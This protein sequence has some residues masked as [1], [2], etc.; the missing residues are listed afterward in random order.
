MGGNLAHDELAMVD[1]TRSARLLLLSDD[2]ETQGWA[3]AA[4]EQAYC[5][6]F[7]SSLPAGDEILASQDG[8]DAIVLGVSA[9]NMSAAHPILRKLAAG[10]EGD[11]R[12]IVQSP[13]D[14]IDEVA[15]ESWGRNVLHVSDPSEAEGAEAIEWVLKREPNRLHDGKG[16]SRLQQLSEEAG[17]IAS[18]L[19]SLSVSEAERERFGERPLDASRVRAIIR[20]R[21]LRDQ[22]LGPELFADPAWDMLLDLLA[23]RLE[24]QQ[25][26]V[27]SLCIAAAVP[28]TTALRWIKALT[29]QGILVRVADPQDGRRIHIELAEQVS[30]ALETYLRAAQRITSDPI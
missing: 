24:G 12:W 27:S 22:F 29:E 26:A 20:A 9:D 4:A 18:A 13:P 21:R 14:A 5:R 1:Y 10:G 25:V 6:T 3:L 19:A 30:V 28:P 23:A 16:T 17:R 8:F 7:S 11:R 15:A 2:P